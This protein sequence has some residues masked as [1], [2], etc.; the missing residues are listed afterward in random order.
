MEQEHP[1]GGVVSGF[2][3]PGDQYNHGAHRRLHRS[4]ND[5][6]I[7]G[8]GGGLGHYFGIDPVLVRL[9]FVALA[10]AGGIGI[11]IYFV[12]AIILPEATDDEDVAVANSTAMT[13]GRLIF[14]GVFIVIGG[15]LLLREIIPWYSDRIVWGVILVAVGLAVVLRRADR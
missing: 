3:T 1:T 6:V 4:R 14:G 12:A 15:Y 9:A 13:E 7:A 11:L 8:V 2:E 10:V 5:R